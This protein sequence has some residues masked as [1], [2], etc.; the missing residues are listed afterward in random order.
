MT[1][2]LLLL[3]MM[4]DTAWAAW[5]ALGVYTLGCITDWLDGYRHAYLDEIPSTASADG[6]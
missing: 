1:I 4:T 2:P 6:A 3:L 5:S